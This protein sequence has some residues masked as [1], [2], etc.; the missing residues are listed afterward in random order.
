[1]CVGWCDRYWVAGGMQPP[2][3]GTLGRG[4]ARRGA[5]APLLRAMWRHRLVCAPEQ[6]VDVQGPDRHHPNQCWAADGAHLGVSVP[7]CPPTLCFTVVDLGVDID[8]VHNNR[9]GLRSG[10]L[11]S[12]IITQPPPL[13]ALTVCTC[14]SA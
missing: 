9:G 3:V 7:L 4:A 13:L 5:A 11:I 10:S 14:L 8:R 2:C 6:L 1:M 12:I